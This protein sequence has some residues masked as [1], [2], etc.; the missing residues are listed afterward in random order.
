MKKQ[1]LFLLSL[2]LL[3]LLLLSAC[4]SKEIKVLDYGGT[5]ENR[6]LAEQETPKN[7]DGIAAADVLDG[8]I[9]YVTKQSDSESA[10]QPPTVLASIEGETGKILTW[11]SLQ[12]SLEGLAEAEDFKLDDIS[13]VSVQ[14]DGSAVLVMEAQRGGSEYEDLDALMEAI[15]SGTDQE[16]KIEWFCEV[17][18]LDADHGVRWS[19]QLPDK[20][21]YGN[22]M[23]ILCDS[24][25][26][27]YVMDGSSEGS[28]EQLLVL[29]SSGNQVYYEQNRYQHMALRQDNAVLLL[30]L[31]MDKTQWEV[32][33]PDP[34]S[35]KMELL[36]T[37][38]LLQDGEATQSHFYAGND[39]FD[40]YCVTEMSLYGIDLGKDGKA[41]AVTQILS[42][43]NYGIEG[44][45][46]QTFC[47]GKGKNFTVLSYSTDFGA[48]L[49]RM[50]WQSKSIEDSRTKL[51]LA[52]R[53][54]PNTLSQAILRFNREN[55][56]YKLLVRDYGSAQTTGIDRLTVDLNA[57]NLPDIFYL[58]DIDQQILIN[59]GYLED[60]WP[61][62]DSDSELSRETLVE[63]LFDAMSIDGKLYTFTNGFNIETTVA[64]KAVVGE[65]PGW[66][67]SRFREL[68]EETP[69]LEY[70]GVL[71]CTQDSVLEQVI[72]LYAQQFVD[73][74]AG[75]A[76]FDSP[77]FIELM[78]YVAMYPQ[79]QNSYTKEELYGLAEGKILYWRVT[80][81]GIEVYDWKT[82]TYIS[83][84]DK[85]AV[86]HK[87]YPGLP[88]NGS[89]FQPEL[90]LA[91]TA[92][93]EHKDVVWSFL[94]TLV[95]EEN[96]DVM[97][98]SGS[99]SV[100]NCFPANQELLEQMIQQ[101]ND[102]QSQMIQGGEPWSQ[103]DID[104][105]YDLINGIT[106]VV[107][108]QEQ[109]EGIIRDEISRFLSG[110]Q[111]AQTAAKA[112]QNRVQ[113]CLD[114]Q[115]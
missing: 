23:E 84:S 58:E 13:A 81:S 115:K 57:G 51:T 85:T 17:V 90:Q 101:Y 95:L 79:S 106:V 87:G 102:K 97:D 44:T 103:E 93:G 100:Y 20:F 10:F 55:E 15:E 96:L 29:D 37:L 111:D 3:L 27:T 65:E 18:A 21:L 94:R 86:V 42:W 47:P 9:Y 48:E 32:V 59:K 26:Y 31:S 25:G 104:A 41:C 76:T 64:L 69:E 63:P 77:E 66:S 109:L 1:K 99:Y 62:I 70:L 22:T 71:W 14:P 43:M 74:E 12:N 114:E 108:P 68:A 2:S 52:C 105:F 38:P 110:Q 54:L 49:T 6:Y 30:R 36:C 98:D 67:L 46:I 80:H 33:Q 34:E 45:T 89:V 113:L 11:Q 91:M 60:L 19:C 92:T 112:I 56:E 72:D 83:V 50:Q 28:Y 61:Y 75:E 40:L 7:N 4:G 24:S 73:W 35:W 78:E 39:W 53:Q 5:G 107:R 82:T 8:T 16:E 88:G